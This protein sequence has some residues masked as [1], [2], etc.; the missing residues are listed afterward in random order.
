MSSPTSYLQQLTTEHI[1][2]ST[3]VL[4]SIA[5]RASSNP[6]SSDPSPIRVRVGHIDHG[7]FLSLSLNLFALYNVEDGRL[8]DVRQERGEV[9]VAV[10]VNQPIELQIRSFLR[11]LSDLTARQTVVRSR[12]LEGKIGSIDAEVQAADAGADRIIDDRL[13][14][15]GDWRSAAAEIAQ[16]AQNAGFGLKITF[17]APLLEVDELY[18][19]LPLLRTIYNTEPTVRLAVDKAVAQLA[20]PFRL[21]GSDLPDTVMNQARNA[22]EFGQIKRFVAHLARDAFVCGNG[23]L[24]FGSERMPQ[25]TLLQPDRV[26]MVRSEEYEALDN[27]GG[28]RL[29]EGH[30]LHFRGAH[31]VNSPYG[32]SVLEPF[33]SIVGQRDVMLAVKQDI[34]AFE[35]EAAL[36]QGPAIRA[37]AD[38]VS[39]LADRTIAEVPGRISE[40]LGGGFERYP[41]PDVD[42]LYFPN[43]IEMNDAVASIR[44]SEGADRRVR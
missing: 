10:V 5:E 41:D 2:A 25:P 13:R 19:R 18:P 28:W 38:E 11:F 15:G 34:E 31:Q 29:I 12:V 42:E 43:L 17:S 3:S 23:Y 6:P 16:R 30:V 20:L 8:V 32:I 26:R 22:M 7:A 14:G 9:I 35:R 36:G 1:E 24:T 27:A 44:F 4:T 33:I 37:W 39:P 21:E 40:V